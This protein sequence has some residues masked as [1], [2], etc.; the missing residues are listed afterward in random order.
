MILVNCMFAVGEILERRNSKMLRR[1]V[2]WKLSAG[3]CWYC[4]IKP[5]IC[6][7][8]LLSCIYIYING[9][10]H[11]SLTVGSSY[12]QGVFSEIHSR[13]YGWMQNVQQTGILGSGRSRLGA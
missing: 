8:G 5:G 1:L 13:V 6:Q 12:S 10:S 4:R 9:T 11:E 3:W 2:G 7:G